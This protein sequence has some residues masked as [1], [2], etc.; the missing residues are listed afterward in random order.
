VKVP[1]GP[2]PVSDRLLAR[3]GVVLCSG[4]GSRMT[5]GH[6]H[7]GRY[8]SYRCPDTGECD[9]RV[10]ISAP[11]VEQAVVQ[12][13]REFLDGVV[14]VRSMRQHVRDAQGRLEKAQE[15]LDA[16][17]AMLDPLEPAA[18]DRLAAAT[19]ERDAA[20]ETV[21]DVLWDDY[22][23]VLLLAQDWDRLSIENQ[24]RAIRAVV[25]AAVVMPLERRGQ[26]PRERVE[27]K[28]WTTEL[29]DRGL[30]TDLT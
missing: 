15:T 5:V 17:I 3:L 10:A 25:R 16:L 29:F 21:L 27:V 6:S 8:R 28:F 12:A 9:R 13:T 2:R 11:A 14:G 7:G 23:E 1:R 30:P 18:R 26:D 19:A 22:D 24:R 20:R 4:C